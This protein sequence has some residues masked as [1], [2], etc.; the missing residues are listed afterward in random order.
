MVGGVKVVRDPARPEEGKNK[1]ESAAAFP[2]CRMI[3][4]MRVD[5]P[6]TPNVHDAHKDVLSKKCGG[7]FILLLLFFSNNYKNPKLVIKKELEEEKRHLRLSLSLVRPVLKFAKYDT[8]NYK[9]P[10]KY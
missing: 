9:T 6:P 7:I 4:A 8:L 3:R 2:E 1:F 10:L 5:T